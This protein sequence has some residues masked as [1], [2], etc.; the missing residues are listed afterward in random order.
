M[1]TGSGM[2]AVGMPQT[3]QTTGPGGRAYVT[4]GREA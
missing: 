4:P 3:I 1:S 2:V